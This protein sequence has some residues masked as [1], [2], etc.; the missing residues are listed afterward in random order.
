VDED[1]ARDL[2]WKTLEPHTNSNNRD[3]WEAIEARQV[4]GE[5]IAERFEGEPAPGC[6]G[7]EPAP[8]QTID[9]SQRY[10][11]VHFE[12]L[13]ATPIPQEGDVPPTAPPIVPEPFIYQAFFLLQPDSG[14]IV[15]M[16]IFCII[17]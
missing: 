11:L 8:N 7:P 16:S 5:A 14:Q 9:P 13:P 15:A 1:Q 6:P 10:W 2:A 12:P 3:R 17:Y 4:S